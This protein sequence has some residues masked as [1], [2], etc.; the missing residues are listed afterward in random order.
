MDIQADLSVCTVTRKPDHNLKRLLTSVYQ[1]S[2]PV[3]VEVIV[4]DISAAGENSAIL[5]QF[6]ELI[7]YLLPGFDNLVAAQ[8][9]AMSMATGRYISLL[10]NDVVC[11]PDCFTKLLTFLDDTPDVG[12][13]GPRITNAYGA[14]E[15]SCRRFF[16]P[17]SLLATYTPLGRLSWGRALKE[18]H[19]MLGFKHDQDMEVDWICGGAHMIRKEVVEEIGFLDEGLAQP[20]A[21]QDYCLRV[22]QSGWHNFYCHQGEIIHTNP[23]RYHLELQEPM[24][25]WQVFLQSNRYL[26]KKWTHALRQPTYSHPTQTG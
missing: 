2:D 1:A 7:I 6:P 10:D 17:L 24:P 23:C 12:I 3:S 21:E 4:V 26:S 5:D 14:S 8:N 18:R 15:P 11:T 22:R 19:C 25:G 16:S 13:A 9:R 20:F